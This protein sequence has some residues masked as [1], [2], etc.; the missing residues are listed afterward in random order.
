MSTCTVQ[1]VTFR[2]QRKIQL[3][4]LGEPDLILFLYYEHR[5]VDIIVV[6][7]LVSNQLSL[8]LIN[9]RF[10]AVLGEIGYKVILL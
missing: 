5:S 8:T 10:L 4:V 6:F 1:S 3:G 2:L 7:R 9:D